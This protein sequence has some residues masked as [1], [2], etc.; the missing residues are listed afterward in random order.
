ML[1]LTVKAK[2]SIRIG[3]VRVIN[4]EC[5]A[6]KVGIEAPLRIAVVREG[7]F[8]FVDRQSVD[9]S[10]VEPKPNRSRKL[11]TKQPQQ[12]RA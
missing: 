3:T 1:C 2:C 11:R 4:R 7:A 5:S 10:R 12:P 6:V 9:E 8:Q